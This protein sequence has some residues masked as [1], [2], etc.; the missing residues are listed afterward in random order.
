MPAAPRRRGPEV[1]QQVNGA[2]RS[3]LAPVQS[4]GVEEAPEVAEVVA[5]G[6]SGVGRAAAGSEVGKEP[7]RDRHGCTR[8]VHDLDRTPAA[9]SSD[10]LTPTMAHLRAN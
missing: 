6:E 9:G 2:L 4:R 1:D 7:S 5:V 8:A 3:Q 10:R